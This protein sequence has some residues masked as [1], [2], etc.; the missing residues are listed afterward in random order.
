MDLVKQGKLL[1]YLRRANGLTQKQVADR[2][3]IVAKTVS[4]WETGK[5]FPDVS[6]IS[7]LA[8]ILGVSER[9]LLSG[10]LNKNS[11]QTGNIKKTK[12]YLCPYCGSMIEGTG[13][14]EIICCGKP[15]EKLT[16]QQPDGDHLITVSEIENDFYIEFNHDMTKE[17]FIRFVAYIGFDRILLVRLYPEQASA[18]RFPKMYGG[19]FY[20]CCSEHGLFEHRMT[21][22]KKG[23]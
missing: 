7:A 11:N 13:E 22:G 2:L 1:S 6:V 16:A 20:Y 5:G 4:K 3:G 17:H 8:D 18:V 9:V 15:I 19:K 21:K 12:F 14:F 10:T 23:K